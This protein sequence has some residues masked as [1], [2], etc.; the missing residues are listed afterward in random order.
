MNKP[1]IP[2][3]WRRLRTGQKRVEGY[4]YRFPIP[5][6]FGPW[7]DGSNDNIGQEILWPGVVAQYRAPIIRRKA[8]KT[9][10]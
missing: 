8:R 4:Q 3:G 5:G 1:I 6:G 9:K 2:L 7:L 10:Q